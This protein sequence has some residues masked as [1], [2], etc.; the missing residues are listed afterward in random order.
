M[1]LD[2]LPVLFYPIYDSSKNSSNISILNSLP[3]D[4]MYDWSG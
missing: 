3:I 2:E 1:S 4:V